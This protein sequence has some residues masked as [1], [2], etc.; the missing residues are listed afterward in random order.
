MVWEY[1]F[2]LWLQNHIVND[3]LTPM[4]KAFTTMGNG[5]AVWIALSIILI[6]VPRTRKLGLVCA[7]TLLLDAILCN[8]ILKTIIARPRPFTEAEII[9]QIPAP[10]GSSFPSGHTSS[11]FAVA[12]AIALRHHKAGI[13]AFAVAV[14][15]AFSRMYFYVHYPTD[16]LGGIAVGV[17]CALAVY[18]IEKNYSRKKSLS[19]SGKA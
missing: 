14:L 9:L 17:G 13:C 5:G 10:M 12:T 11:S 3:T 8:L 19:T 4:M 6:C 16:I 7:V 15:I 2:L 18:Y 1:S